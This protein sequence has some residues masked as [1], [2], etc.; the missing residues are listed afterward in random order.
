MEEELAVRVC[1]LGLRAGTYSI[2]CCD[3][4]STIGPE[5]PLYH[6]MREYVTTHQYLGKYRHT[7]V[8]RELPNTRISQ[9][10]RLSQPYLSH[11]SHL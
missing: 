6:D 10:E 4:V 2:S 5:V 8:D 3:I 11:L 7:T 1:H 9:C